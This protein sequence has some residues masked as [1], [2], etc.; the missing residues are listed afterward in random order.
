[1]T[2]FKICCI[3]NADEA[4][5]A[6]EAGASA[7]GFVSEMPSGPGPIPEDHIAFIIPTVPP[8]VATFLLTS[9]TDA[10]SIIQQQRYT[11]ANTLQLVD[12]V[13]VETY[14]QLQS[15]LQGIAI[16][17]VIHV[18]GLQSL[19]E[20][21]SVAPYVDG[22]LLDSGNP[23]LPVKV[24]GGTGMVHDWKISRQIVELSGK[25]VFLAGGLKGENVGEAIKAVGPYAVDVCSGVRTNGLLDMKKLKDFVVA[26]K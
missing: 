10:T 3:Q 23:D 20:A 1:M 7:L 12:A 22:I 11:R 18:R 17:Q 25:P 19:D 9:K 21:V 13:S 16:V 4:R 6:V 26:L 24:L 5:I 2:R 14:K 8:G 15:T